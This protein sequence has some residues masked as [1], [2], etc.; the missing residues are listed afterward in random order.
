MR[1][2]FKTIAALTI[3][4]AVA[5]L[6]AT[7]AS[8]ADAIVVTSITAPVQHDDCGPELVEGG[9]PND[10]IGYAWDH[11]TFGKDAGVSKS[12]FWF[13]DGSYLV[14]A[15]PKPGYVIDPAIQRAWRF[16]AFTD[17]PCE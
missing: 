3:A 1:T 17:V 10:Y 11:W 15:D 5:V 9:A 14:R 12:V 7:S 13:A 4:G 16:P 2:A 6:G 8:A